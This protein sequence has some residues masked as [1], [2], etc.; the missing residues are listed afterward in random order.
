[1]VI[2]FALA[3]AS[4]W[5]AACVGASTCLKSLTS[6]GDGLKL[7]AA[8]LAKNIGGGIHYM[9]VCQSI[10]LLHCRRSMHRQYNGSNLF[11]PYK[12][13]GIWSPRR[14]YPMCGLRWW[15]LLCWLVTWLRDCYIFRSSISCHV[16]SE[17]LTT[18]N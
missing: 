11:P 14:C 2:S 12:Y 3:A 6:G 17:N 4:T 16:S 15:Y 9:A 8:L 18:D 1:M 7:A 10:T 5:I 13:I